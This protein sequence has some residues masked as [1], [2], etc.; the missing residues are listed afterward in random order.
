M[1][2]PTNTRNFDRDVSYRRPAAW[3]R[4]K[5]MSPF[6]AALCLEVEALCRQGPVNCPRECLYAALHHFALAMTDAQRMAAWMQMNGWHQG[7]RT[8]RGEFRDAAQ[9]CE[10]QY[11]E[12]HTLADA[13]ATAVIS[14]FAPE[15][16]NELRIIEKAD[17]QPGDEP[18]SR[19][20]WKL[21]VDQGILWLY[22]DTPLGVRE[23]IVSEAKQL[24][25]QRRREH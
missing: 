24:F 25:A 4:V 5:E 21:D 6:C 3:R 16:S 19:C 11:W 7:Q 12:T 18:G 17:Y 1:S 15:A 13:V 8:A 2:D 10:A 23:E 14:S 9:Q 22:R 20:Y